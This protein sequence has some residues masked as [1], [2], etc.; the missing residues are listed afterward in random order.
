ML[1]FPERARQDHAGQEARHSRRFLQGEGLVYRPDKEAFRSHVL[2]AYK[3]SKYS[4]GGP[5][6]LLD[7]SNSL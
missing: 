1:Q 5:E 6:G 7:R 3:N 2:D 4:A